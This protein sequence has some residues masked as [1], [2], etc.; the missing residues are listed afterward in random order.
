MVFYYAEKSCMNCV[1][2]NLFFEKISDFSDKLFFILSFLF[3]ISVTCMHVCLQF[4]LQ[5]QKFC[6]IKCVVCETGYGSWFPYPTLNYRTIYE[7]MFAHLRFFP[8]RCVL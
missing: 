2:N 1:L 6:K 3:Y 5:I 4:G 8:V 7:R